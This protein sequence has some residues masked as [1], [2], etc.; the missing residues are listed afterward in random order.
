MLIQITSIFGII[1]GTSSLILAILILKKYIETKITATFIL[2]LILLGVN[3]HGYLL[4][5]IILLPSYLYFV[6]C[7]LF[8]TIYIFAFV[9]FFLFFLF[10]EYIDSG[11]VRTTLMY[12]VAGLI[13]ALY[14][15]L[16]IPGQINVQ[17][18]PFFLVWI[19]ETDPL[20]ELALLFLGIIL[21]FK[22]LKA[23][24]EIMDHTASIKL[25]KQFKLSVTG[26][27]I[28]FGGLVFLTS[29]GNIIAPFNLLVGGFI[30]GSYPLILIPG[31]VLVYRAY[32]LNPY[33]VFLIAQK[34]YKLIVFK[35]G[36]VTIY[37]YEFI[38]SPSKSAG[39][40]HGAIHGVSSM[41]QTALGIESY[42]KI[43]QYSDRVIL[44]EFQEGIGFA[45]ITDRDSS[46][47]RDGLKGFSSKFV[48]EFKN[49]IKNWKGEFKDTK[50]ASLLVK[51][52]FPF[53][54]ID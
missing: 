43:I 8:Y 17:F 18:N 44:F 54:D 49:E 50:K 10:F 37:E 34:I 15:I 27:L 32:M 22:I 5:T 53:A 33:S 30:R 41:I 19:S 7:G 14:M 39:L 2:F 28:A 24:K 21:F 46:V 45:L 20:I 23:F 36:A 48:Q 42:P 4:A 52:S 29:V 51:T 26:I 13:G 16:F 9:V 40:I 35:E 47:L 6:A 3:Q 25:K 1:L 31:L 11:H 38:S 12:V